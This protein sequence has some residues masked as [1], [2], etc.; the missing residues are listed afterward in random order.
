MLTVSGWF[1]FKEVD[2]VV[3]VGFVFFEF[4]SFET[5]GI[6]GIMDRLFHDQGGIT[7][8]FLEVRIMEQFIGS[9]PG[10]VGI[11]IIRWVGKN[12]IRFPALQ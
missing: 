11:R 9:F 12:Q 3:A 10:A 5:G 1:C 8:P 7:G 4:P 2:E 6:E